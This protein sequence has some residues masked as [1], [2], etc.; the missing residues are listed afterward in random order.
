MLCCRTPVEAFL[1]PFKSRAL[2]T[3]GVCLTL[4]HH[5][6]LSRCF[7][8]AHVHISQIEPGHPQLFQL[9]P[10]RT[11]S[12]S[13]SLKG[14]AKVTLRLGV[15]LYEMEV[16]AWSQKNLAM[17]SEFKSYIWPPPDVL[18]AVVL[19]DS[20]SGQLRSVKI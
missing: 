15:V 18:L 19:C 14:K 6:L 10:P 1:T 20:K 17:C 2:N 4:C 8:A 7:C 16:R 9:A 11:K 3:R 13:T 12:R 5:Q